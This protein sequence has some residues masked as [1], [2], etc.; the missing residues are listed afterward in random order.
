[1]KKWIT[2]ALGILLTLVVL[3]GVGLAGYRMGLMQGASGARIVSG[4][5]PEPGRPPILEKRF[6]EGGPGFAWDIGPGRFA[7]GHEHARGGRHLR[8]P[9]FGLVHL[10]VI[11]LLIWLGYAIYKNSGWQFVRVSGGS[12]PEAA[13]PERKPRRKTKP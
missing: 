9:F 11:G 13:S 8:F 2:Y 12:G 5:P 3:A 6:N 10:L 7:Q 4:R 1:M